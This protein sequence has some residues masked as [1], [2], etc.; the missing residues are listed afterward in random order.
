MQNIETK[1][2]SDDYRHNKENEKQRVRMRE[3]TFKSIQYREMK[4]KKQQEAKSEKPSQSDA[5]R[6]EENKNRE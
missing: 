2:R 6:Q 3:K 5:Y 4:K 1:Q